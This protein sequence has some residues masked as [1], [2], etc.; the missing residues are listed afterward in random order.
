MAATRISVWLALFLGLSSIVQA[1]DLTALPSCGIK[2]LSQELGLSNCASTNQTCLCADD[3]FIGQVQTCILASCT[4]KESLIVKNQTES[5][6]GLSSAGSSADTSKVIR[7]VRAFTLV[8]PTIPLIM[9]IAN[10][11]MRISPWG[12]DDTTIM[13][14]YVS[15]NAGSGE[16]IWTLKPEQITE[17]LLMFYVLGICY[18]T[19]LAAIKASILFLYLRI[20]PDARFRRI[21]WY[22]QLVNLVGYIVFSTTAIFSCR[23]TS[24]FWTGWAK[25]TEGECVNLNA[26]SEVHGGFNVILDV[27]MLALPLSQTHN[28]NMKPKKK[29]GIMLMFGIGMFLTAV[30][31]YRLYVLRDFAKSYNFTA[32]SFQTAIWSTIELGVGIFVACLPSSRGFGRTL[33]PK[34]LQMTHISSRSSR[35]AANNTENSR[36]TP[37]MRSSGHERHIVSSEESSISELVGEHSNKIPMHDLVQSNTA[38]TAPSQTSKLPKHPIRQPMVDR[39]RQLSMQLKSNPNEHGDGQ[40]KV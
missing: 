13:V 19:S 7:Q 29:L 23:P 22:T 30:S 32:G 2:C 21:M 36:R 15:E 4:V 28:L 25:E 39:I 40:E 3:V 38:I 24:Y 26:L 8:F 5:A 35:S 10:K 6:C 1:A 27:W 18:I 16:D 11:W 20:F 33:F 12:W 37:I 9:R 17:I 34:L 31:A 14:A